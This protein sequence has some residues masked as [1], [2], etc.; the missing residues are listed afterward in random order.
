MLGNVR[1]LVSDAPLRPR[2]DEEE[3]LS[4]TIGPPGVPPNWLRLITGRGRPASGEEEVVG[5]QFAVAEEFP[6]AAIDGV[7]AG[8]GDHGDIATG[9]AALVAL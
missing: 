5:V 9:I 2:G 3:G 1:L 8:L 7:F 4:F 6:G